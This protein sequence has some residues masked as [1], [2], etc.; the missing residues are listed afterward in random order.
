MTGPRLVKVLASE[1][2]AGVPPPHGA[3]GPCP[4][5]PPVAGPSKGKDGTVHWAEHRGITRLNGERRPVGLGIDPSPTGLA[6]AIVDADTYH[7]WRLKPRTKVTREG[8]GRPYRLREIAEFIEARIRNL[9]FQVDVRHICLEGYAFGQ[10]GAAHSMG[11]V[12]GILRLKLLNSPWPE[13]LCFPTLVVTSQLKKFA[14]GAG[15]AEKSQI[16]KAV[17][18]KWGVDLDD[19]NMADAFTLAK[20][21]F[22]ISAGD[23]DYGY[24]ADVLA[25]LRLHSEWDQQSRLQLPPSAKSRARSKRT[26]AS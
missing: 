18:K 25:N 1:P 11:E 21:A 26:A 14:T 15:N 24:E 17:Y 22:A 19:D 13:P 9:S 8:E 16:L 20:M 23:T 2:P 7:V 5:P 10:A 12:G 6:F 3:E 4:S